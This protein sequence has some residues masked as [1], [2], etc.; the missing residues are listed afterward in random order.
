M[1][2]IN[3]IKILMLILVILLSTTNV[4]SQTTILSEDF[5]SMTTGY[6]TQSVS[7]S[8]NYQVVNNCTYE[9][10]EVT[11]SHNEECSSCTGNFVAIEWYGSSCTQDNVF[12]TKQ[13]SPSE[14]TISISFDYLFDHYS[15]DYFE[16]YLYNETDGVQVGVDLVYVTIDTDGSFSGSVNLSGSNSN[17]DNL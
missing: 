7:T 2:L 12:I 9:T 15:G 10:W 6:V 1:S 13:F 3:N 14:S 16:V 5:S 11:T 8:T 17:S 4:I